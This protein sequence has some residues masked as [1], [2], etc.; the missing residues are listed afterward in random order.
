MTVAT[1]IVDTIFVDA[2]ID[3][4]SDMNNITLDHTIGMA[5]LVWG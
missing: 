1:V 2:V 4:A 3:D 5:L